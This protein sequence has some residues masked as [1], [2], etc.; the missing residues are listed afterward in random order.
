MGNLKADPLAVNAIIHAVLQGMNTMPSDFPRAT[1]VDRFSMIYHTF[2][3]WVEVTPGDFSILGMLENM[4]TLHF[5]NNPYQPPIQVNDFSFLAQCRKLK[6]LDLACTNFSDCSILLQLPPLNYVR[7]PEKSRLTHLE[8]LDQ[9]PKKTR[10]SFLSPPASQTPPVAAPPL[11]KTPEGSEKVKAI[12][13]EL[14]RRT[15]TDCY[16]MHIQPDSLPKLTDSKFGGYPYWNPKLPYPVD[17]AGEKLV[18]LAQINFDQFPVDEPL[19]QGGM[20]QFFVGQD[21]IFGADGAHPDRQTNFR[22]VYHETIDRSV[23]VQQL[24]PLNLP[25]HADLDYFP[26]LKSA[27]VTLERGVSCTGLSVELFR[28]VTHALTGEE[29]TGQ[30]P[31]RYLGDEDFRYFIDHLSTGGHRMLGWPYFTQEDPR[32]ENSPYDT[33]LFQI[34]SDGSREADY[35]LWGDSGV[36][37]FFINLEDLKRRDFT[38]VFYTWDCC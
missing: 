32:P 34:D 22:V 30:S 19:P 25:T 26:V 4:H 18:L 36:A 12:V 2:P 3:H 38:K 16:I 24:K 29:M 15:A 20:L 6:R 27:A 28:E 10:V 17:G 5:P 31:Y 11:P 23:T 1:L 9:L 21:D 37:N 33:L 7:L 14:K 13:A 8:A 35:V